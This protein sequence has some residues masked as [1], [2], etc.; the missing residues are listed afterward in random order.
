VI[1]W[2][3]NKNDL[4][5]PQNI[6]YNKYPARVLEAF[7]DAFGENPKVAE[8]VAWPKNGVVKVVLDWMLACCNGDGIQPVKDIN[9]DLSGLTSAKDDGEFSRFF[10]TAYLFDFAQ[11]YKIKHLEDKLK[12][13]LEFQAKV[14]IRP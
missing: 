10:K 3:P 13:E 11:E 1:W 4:H 9:L 14:V 6:V 12:R 5:N 7:S 2:G 8:F